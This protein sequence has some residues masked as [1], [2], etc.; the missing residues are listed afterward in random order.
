M[1]LQTEI[2]LKEENNQIDY[3]SNILLL[4][5]CFA[6][7]IGDKIAYFK[8]QN[9]QNPLGILFN[10]VVIERLVLNAIDKKP[11]TDETV[12]FHNGRWHSFDAHSSLSA[13]SKETLIQHL[14]DAAKKTRHSIEKAS[15]IVVT[16]GTAWIY[17]HKAPNKVVA[18]CHKLPQNE[19]VKELLSVEKVSGSI[20]SIVN[21]IKRVN[22]NASI[23]F[24]V[25]PVRHLKDGFTENQHSKAHLISAIHK[26]VSSQTKPS[27]LFY[28]PSYEI[29]MDEL[30]DY[31]FYKADMIHPNQTAIDYIWGK[32]KY[33]WVSSNAFGV[34]D[35][36][37]AIQKGLRHKP[38]NSKSSEYESFIKKIKSKQKALK[39]KYSYMKF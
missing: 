28:F 1:K 33:V 12:F 22:T 34:M 20:N 31:R 13:V 17:T 2:K 21:A 25:S 30:R 9:L 19:F 26:L 3:N 14:N 37:N 4:G 10:P 23:I 36:V 6:Q 35:E 27:K 18:S 16:L 8:F 5:S 32:F 39:K 24:T 11:F 38:F 29:M 7:N 15:H